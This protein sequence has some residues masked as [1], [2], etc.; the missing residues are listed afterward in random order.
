MNDFHLTSYISAYFV[1]NARMIGFFIIAPIL[2]SSNLSGGVRAAVLIALGLPA[3]VIFSR[4]ESLMSLVD[5]EHG[6]TLTFILGKEL[7]IG[8]LLGLAIAAV[9]WSIELMGMFIDNQRGATIASSMDPVSGSQSSPI[10]I[11]MMQLFI[12]Y[13]I[14][15]GGFQFLL[16]GLAQSY[17]LWRIDSFY[18]SFEITDGLYFLSMM[19]DMLHTGVRIAAPVIIA[20]MLGEWSLALISRFAPQLNVF[21]VSFSIKSGVAIFVLYIY[22]AVLFP[23][24][25][26]EFFAMERVLQNTEEVIGR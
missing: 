2:S 12:A 9:F 10:G 4:Q 16:A 14:I 17:V 23:Y 7:L 6:W 13:F 25:R 26:D 11:M 24:L 15:S 22:V 8:F 1:A 19:D 5:L 3:M 21:N 18:P 20:M